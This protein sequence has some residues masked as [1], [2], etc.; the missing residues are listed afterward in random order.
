MYIHLVLQMEAARLSGMSVPLYTSTS[1]KTVIQ[2][3]CFFLIVSTEYHVS[4]LKYRDNF[5]FK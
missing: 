2:I 1:M 5:D 3:L 4:K